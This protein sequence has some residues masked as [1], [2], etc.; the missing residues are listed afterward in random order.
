M[1]K[2]RLTHYDCLY[3]VIDTEQELKKITDFK[4][5]IHAEFDTIS[6]ENYT[7]IKL[8]TIYINNVPVKLWADLSYLGYHRAKYLTESFKRMNEALERKG[9]ELLTIERNNTGELEAEI[10]V[11][12]IDKNEN[13]K[14]LEFKQKYKTGIVTPAITKLIIN[15]ILEE[16]NYE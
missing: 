11:K 9:Y 10:I 6:I 7:P 13:I 4:G 1:N 2:I 16:Q 5:S 12:L 8:N 14:I 3:N 15:K